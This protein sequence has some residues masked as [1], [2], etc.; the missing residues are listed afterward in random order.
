VI[1]LQAVAQGISLRILVNDGLANKAARDVEQMV[2][3]CRL[4]ATSW[5]IE[6]GFIVITYRLATAHARQ[7]VME[8]IR[9]Q[10]AK[11]DLPLVAA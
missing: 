8:Q 7:A 5:R 6:P 11:Y 3:V 4:G 9:M 10:A 1:K 2:R